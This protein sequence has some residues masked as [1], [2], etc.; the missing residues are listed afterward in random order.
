MEEKEEE[1]VSLGGCVVEDEERRKGLIGLGL[2]ECDC[3]GSA[4]CSLQHPATERAM[5]NETLTA[6]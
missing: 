5:L 4:M 3:G 2:P 6:V 1:A